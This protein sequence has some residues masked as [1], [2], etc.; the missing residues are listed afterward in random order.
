MLLLLRM[1]ARD[2][3]GA[4]WEALGGGARALFGAE[5]SPSRRI[6]RA[7]RREGRCAPETRT[8]THDVPAA[9][10]AARRSAASSTRSAAAPTRRP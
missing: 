3:V 7:W 2:G 1:M 6:A 4:D 8:V 10:L 9:P 5:G